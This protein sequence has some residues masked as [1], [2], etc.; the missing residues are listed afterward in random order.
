MSCWKTNNKCVFSGEGSIELWDLSTGTP[1]YIN[2]FKYAD[3]RSP[4]SNMFE[5]IIVIPDTEYFLAGDTKDLSVT[6]WK[7]S[8]PEVLAELQI[9]LP[10]QTQDLYEC[11][12]IVIIPGTRLAMLHYDTTDH[13]ILMDFVDM[14]KIREIRNNPAVVGANQTY[15][16]FKCDAT[17]FWSNRF[18]MACMQERDTGEI[19][20]GV[21]DYATGQHIFFL[22]AN[23]PPGASAVTNGGLVMFRMANVPQTPFFLAGL[24]FVMV[25]YRMTT[26]SDLVATQQQILGAIGLKSVVWSGNLKRFLATMEYQQE[27]VSI[28]RGT[29]CSIECNISGN[30]LDS[31]PFYSVGCVACGQGP[32]LA[33]GLCPSPATGEYNLPDTANAFAG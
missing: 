28:I 17:T 9:N 10:L 21:Y 16:E 6:R 22:D 1:T 13:I 2:S 25:F 33:N 32:K 27:L 24:K 12:Q 30:C 8:D 3:K 26:D 23:G 14:V 11:E 20:A 4:G 7:A 5:A 15:K 19:D 29:A 31:T 18:R